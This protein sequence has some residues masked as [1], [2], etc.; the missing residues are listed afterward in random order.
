MLNVED[1]R[2]NNITITS[3]GADLLLAI[4]DNNRKLIEEFEAQLGKKKTP[5]RKNV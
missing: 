5:T 3:T 4:W 2:A 1:S